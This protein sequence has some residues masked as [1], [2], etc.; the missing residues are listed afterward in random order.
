MDAE[1]LQRL[2]EDANR[3]AGMMPLKGWYFAPYEDGVGLWIGDGRLHG[4]VQGTTPDYYLF[5]YGDAE[6]V[7]YAI[8]W[9]SG[10]YWEPPDCNER[11][12]CSLVLGGADEVVCAV[13]GDLVDCVWSTV[14]ESESLKKMEEKAHG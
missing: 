1:S 8:E 3:L 7:L 12:V 9:D 4:P 2:C 5:D 14:V 6:F 10:T 11:M 13:F